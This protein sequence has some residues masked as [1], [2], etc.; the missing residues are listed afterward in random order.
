MMPTPARWSLRRQLTIFVVVS[1]LLHLLIIGV[2]HLPDYLN[3]RRAARPLA[4]AR[5]VAR[6]QAEERARAAQAARAQATKAAVAATKQEVAAQLAS[7]FKALVG[8]QLKPDVAADVWQDLMAQLSSQL[9]RYGETLADEGVSD[10]DAR[11]ELAQ[12]QGQMLDDLLIRLRSMSARELAKTFIAKIQTEVAPQ[13]A[14]YYRKQIEQRIGNALRDEGSKIV[15]ADADPAGARLAIKHARDEVIRQDLD[16]AFRE[17]YARTA[18]PGLSDKLTG[19]FKQTLEVAGAHDDAVVAEVDKQVRDALGEKLHV[20][21]A[22]GQA[23]TDALTQAEHLN[24]LK[25]DAD[26]EDEQSGRH[27]HGPHGKLHHGHGAGSHST[28]EPSED[29]NGTETAIAGVHGSGHGKSDH[30]QAV[31]ARIEGFAHGLTEDAMVG[32]GN[33]TGVDN[34][35]VGLAGGQKPAQPHGDGADADGAAALAA[36]LQQLAINVKGGR[37][38]LAN[39]SGN[40]GHAGGIGIA[41]LRQAAYERMHGHAFRDRTYMNLTEYNALTAGLADRDPAAARGQAATR[42]SASGAALAD[43]LL[44]DTK[45][46]SH[47]ARLLVPSA[48]KSPADVAVEQHQPF[49]PAFKTI[50]FAAIPFRSKPV[51][52]DGDLSEWNDVPALP[53]HPAT[54]GGKRDDLKKFPQSVKAVWDNT[55]FYVAY[56][57]KDADNTI[58]KADPGNFWEGDAVEVW[59]DALNTKEKRRTE[60]TYQ[61]WAWV[62]GSARDPAKVGGESISYGVRDEFIPYRSDLIQTASKK[63]PDGWSIEFHVPVERFS[64]TGHIDLTPGRIL[65]MNFSI[66]T[67]TPLYYYWAGTADVETAR[68]PNTWG[69]VILAGSAG[70]VECIDKLASELKDGTAAAISLN[71][72]QIGEPLRIRVSDA[73]MNLSDQVKDKLA[74]TVSTPRGQRHVVVLEE[75]SPTSGVFEGAIRTT[76]DTGEPKLDVLSLFEGESIAILYTDACGPGGERDIPVKLTLPTAA[77]IG[78]IAGR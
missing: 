19:A 12:L 49:K 60:S 47:P 21:V 33:D 7:E 40:A 65:G 23:G 41:R 5:L 58:T 27:A 75:T 3:A 20:K 9:D 63:T 66:C 62:A 37:T 26:G 73:D 44:A 72:L 64:R 51:T 36:R 78:G 67:G 11:A 56:D 50:A 57:V 69:D 76:L 16:R 14:D 38:D 45:S 13:V 24:E 39:V 59:F 2:S 29:P 48:T 8:D 54:S 35:A 32:I 74:V 53:L 68:H 6:Q 17:E 18:L 77:A 30:E 70:K 34:A 43:A 42:E 71:F 31:A 25:D 28:T 55:G 10:A 61:F 15:R 22:A 46:A 52:I 1:V 4:A